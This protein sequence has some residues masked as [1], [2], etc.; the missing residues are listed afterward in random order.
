MAPMAVRKAAYIHIGGMDE[1]TSESGEC[2]KCLGMENTRAFQICVNCDISYPVTP[3]C[4][5]YAGILTDWEL[6][7]REWQCEWKYECGDILYRQA[8]SQGSKLLRPFVY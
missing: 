3:C 1:S 2:G 6:C 8:G 5:S 4:L 7:I